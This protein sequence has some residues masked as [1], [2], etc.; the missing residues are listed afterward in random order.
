[1]TREKTTHFPYRAIVFFD[2]DVFIAVRLMKDIEN[3]RNRLRLPFSREKLARLLLPPS[4]AQ[5]CHRIALQVGMPGRT[6]P[7]PRNP[8]PRI[9]GG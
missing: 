3:D 5:G 1:M 7:A 6:T 9:E 8:D 2:D 4:T